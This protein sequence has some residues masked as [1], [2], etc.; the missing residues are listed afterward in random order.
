[1]TRLYEYSYLVE[2]SR[3]VLIT[4]EMQIEIGFL[5]SRYL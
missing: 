1:V 5:R 2:T 4:A 3:R